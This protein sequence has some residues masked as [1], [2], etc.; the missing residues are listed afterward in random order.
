MNAEIKNEIVRVDD[1][2]QGKRQMASEC[3]KMF[4][5]L[6]WEKSCKHPEYTKVAELLGIAR[7]EVTYNAAL[8]NVT[9]GVALEELDDILQG[10]IQDGID[11][12]S[13]FRQVF[14][15]VRTVS[16]IVIF[17]TRAEISYQEAVE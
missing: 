1:Y 3:V 7:T 6:T 15:W 9:I 17:A 13:D 8:A 10:L 4:A 14:D 16:S 2:T 11:D 12:R 5:N